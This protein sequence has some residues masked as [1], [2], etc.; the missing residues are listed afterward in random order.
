MNTALRPFQSGGICHL[1]TNPDR[2]FRH[3]F[4]KLALDCDGV[5]YPG[6]VIVTNEQRTDVTL[7][8]VKNLRDELPGILGKPRQSPVVYWSQRREDE[9]ATLL[10]A[11][12]QTPVF[13]G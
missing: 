2:T 6:V 4:L 12:T 7:F 1:W 13:I 3:I 10:S 8:T 9:C 5:P 11:L